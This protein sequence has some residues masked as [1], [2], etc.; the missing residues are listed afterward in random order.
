[1]DEQQLI[2]A[3]R[4]HALK[5][6]ESGW[7]VLVECYDDGD[8]LEVVGRCRSADSAIR[9]MAKRLGVEVAAAGYVVMTWDVDG[10]GQRSYKSLDG[11]LKRFAEMAGYLPFGN[12]EIAERLEAGRGVSAV[13]MY[14]TRVSLQLVGV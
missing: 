8:I 4:A 14:G 3:V 13:S 1:M 12:D 5:H 10:R 9:T 2:E 11:A 7:D 6:Y